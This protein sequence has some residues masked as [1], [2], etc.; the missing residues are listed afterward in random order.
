MR[1]DTTLDLS[2]KAETVKERDTPLDPGPNAQL[3]YGAVPVWQ[4]ATSSDT[5][6][7]PS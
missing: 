4:Y 7:V 6:F 5:W 1:T 3:L 2:Q